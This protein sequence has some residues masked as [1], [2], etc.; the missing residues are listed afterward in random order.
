VR[1]DGVDTAGRWSIL[2]H[3]DG[4]VDQGAVIEW[5]AR[6][7]LRRYGVVC[8]RVLGRELQAPPWRDLLKVFRRLEL[9][10]EIRGGRFVSGLSGEQ[11]AL[12]D[13]VTRLREVRRTRAD[14]QLVVISAA[15]PLNLVGIVSA[16]ERVRA[17]AGNRI[18]YRDGVPLACLEGDYI[19]P[20][21]AIDPAQAASVASALAG[22]AVPP[23]IS[24]YVGK[25]G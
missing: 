5:Q 19:R 7:L 25:A 3:D 14:G 17:V 15:D 11:F 10:G 24:G 23:V 6:T 1:R 16:G 13:A 12:A 21:A 9:A 2:E 18:V 8:R 4:R 20:L 22:R